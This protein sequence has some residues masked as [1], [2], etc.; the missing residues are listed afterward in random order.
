MGSWNESHF[1]NLK[2]AIEKEQLYALSKRL[3][4]IKNDISYT[5]PFNPTQFLNAMKTHNKAK[6]A[7]DHLHQRSFTKK[8]E[9]AFQKTLEVF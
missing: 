2:T 3:A 8:Q 9:K 4:K 5:L 1:K 7:A 6:K